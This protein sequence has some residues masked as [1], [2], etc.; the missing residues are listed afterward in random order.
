MTLQEFSRDVVPILQ[1]GVAFVG[2]G[3]LLLVWWQI[4]QTTIWNRLRTS[5][6]FL[7][8]ATLEAS[9]K[10]LSELKRIGVPINT[11]IPLTSSE[12]ELVWKDHEALQA[13]KDIANDMESTCAAVR[14][15]LVDPTVAFKLHNARITRFYKL[16]QPLINKLRNHYDVDD[17]MSELQ[18]LA[19]E[20]QERIDE[21]TRVKETQKRALGLKPVIK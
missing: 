6:T 20:W 7:A 18:W 2:L 17:L 3:S 16:Y 11:G 19:H 8:P 21:D 10:F 1:L 12:V 4:R 5:Y 9:R 14:L 15:G 13:F